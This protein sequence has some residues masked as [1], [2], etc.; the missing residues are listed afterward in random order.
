MSVNV[1]LK[2]DIIT[3]YNKVFTLSSHIDKIDMAS[4]A[5]ENFRFHIKNVTLTE[6]FSWISQLLNNSLLL[7]NF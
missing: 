2:L 6:K 3:I 7:D 4:L 5:G 1:C